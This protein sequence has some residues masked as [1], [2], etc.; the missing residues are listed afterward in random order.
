MLAYTIIRLCMLAKHRPNQP[1]IAGWMLPSRNC[2][3]RPRYHHRGRHNTTNRSRPTLADANDSFVPPAPIPVHVAS[4]EI[5][6]EPIS[7]EQPVE[8]TQ[9]PPHEW[10]KVVQTV[11]NPPPAY[12][13]WRGSV[14]ANPD[15]LH[16]QPIPSPKSPELPPSPTYEEVMASTQNGSPPSYVTRDSPARRREMDDVEERVAQVAHVVE[17]EMVEVRTVGV[18]TAL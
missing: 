6:M 15:L 11:Q 1:A 16:W 2:Y 14:R 3:V 7:A 10:N 12:G 13:R 17:P 4:D 9:I 18:G 5:S 8:A